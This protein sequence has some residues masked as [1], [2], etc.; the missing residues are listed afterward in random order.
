MLFL[1]LE[2]LSILNFPTFSRRT[3]SLLKL[4]HH[5]ATLTSKRIFRKHEWQE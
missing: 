1:A 3:F 4:W 2:H 5:K